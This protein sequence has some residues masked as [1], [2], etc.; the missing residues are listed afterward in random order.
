M[1]LV[2]KV[3]SSIFGN[4][5]KRI[6]SRG[7]GRAGQGRAGEAFCIGLLRKKLAQR[8]ESDVAVVKVP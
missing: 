2:N 7:Q 6:G 4:F 1:D 8:V 3:P 5:Y